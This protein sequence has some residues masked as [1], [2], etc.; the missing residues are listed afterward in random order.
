MAEQTDLGTR[1]N[2]AID[3]KGLAPET[4]VQLDELL[5]Q[6]DRTNEKRGKLIARVVEAVEKMESRPEGQLT[7]EQ[8]AALKR[9]KE[10]VKSDLNPR[11]LPR[12]DS[13]DRLSGDPKNKDQQNVALA[14]S[15][16]L[17]GSN[18][19]TDN[20]AVAQSLYSVLDLVTEYLNSPE[21]EQ[22]NAILE[23]LEKFESSDVTFLAPLLANM[24]P[25]K[26]DLVGDYS[27]REPIEFFVTL[28]GPKVDPE[29]KRY[30][31]LAHLPTEYD[32]YKRYPMMLS[33]PGRA[34]VEN[35][36]KHWCGGF[37]EGLGVRYGHASRCLLYTSP[38]PRD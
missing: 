24:L 28:D 7:E 29:P 26:H 22:R 19:A 4:T 35:Q 12:L 6:V 14:I 33:L 21:E 3:R 10:Q 16:W 2:K 34:K 8:S 31:C 30:R 17:L 13:F 18:N 32:P 36:L 20:W 38:S 15:G 9:F 27:G 11:N 1:W 37:N 23:Q 5:D 25:P